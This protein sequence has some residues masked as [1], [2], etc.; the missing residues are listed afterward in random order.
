M[1]Y[2]NNLAESRLQKKKIYNEFFVMLVVGLIISFYML[3]SN[4]IIASP[5]LKPSDIS[6]GVLI[7]QGFYIGAALVA[8]WKALNRITP[9]IFLF[10]PIIGW[11]VYFVLKIF[12]SG[13]IGVFLLPIRL[14]LNIRKLYLFKK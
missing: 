4:S 11:V 12:L 8:G 9:N 14:F 10:L 1:E 7:F 13:V 2:S 5:T 3:Y 6:K